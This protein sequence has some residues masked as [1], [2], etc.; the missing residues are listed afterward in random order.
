M[1]GS[2]KVL[3][4]EKNDKKN[5]FLIFGFSM[6]NE[7][8][9]KL[10]LKLFRNLCF[11]KLFNLYIM[12]K[13][14]LNE[15]EKTYK[16]NLTLNILFVFF[17]FFFPSTF[18]L[19]FLSLIFSLQF[20]ENQTQPYYFKMTSTHDIKRSI[21]IPWNHLLHFRIMGFKHF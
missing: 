3:R 20:S 18:S 4:K 7:K 5:G 17:Y 11:L 9:N 10:K 13:N 2:Q 21:C 19:Y 16:N 12:N 15:F 8:E 6:G 14:K 1:F